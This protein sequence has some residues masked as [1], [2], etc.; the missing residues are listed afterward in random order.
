MTR[1]HE[2]QVIIVTGGAQGIGLQISQY[3]ESLGATI[4]IADINV[5]QA[6]AAIETLPTKNGMAIYCDVTSEEATTK[7]AEAVIAAY[8][9]IDVLINN[10]G[11]F[12]VKLFS[13]MTE[14]D[15]RKVIDIDL[16]GTFLA[17]KSVYPYMEK[18]KKGKIVNMASISGRVGGVGFTHYSA[19]KAGVIGFTKALAREAGPLG[20]QVNCVAPGI[21]D[22]ETTR[23]VFPSFALKDYT[24]NVPLGRL[25][26]EED[27][28]GVVSFLCSSNSD[29]MTGQCLTVD[30]GYTM[31]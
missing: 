6:Q 31:I 4:V 19:A 5:T 13:Q 22:T 25:G 27:I 7:M 16:T 14:K 26:H 3:L 23:N 2:N 21:I 20:I 11:C 29:Y 28:Q 24:R 9:R 10:A 8:G 17:T 1:L 18:A 30:G 12:P 15:W